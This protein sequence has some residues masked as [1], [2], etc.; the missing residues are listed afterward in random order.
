[1]YALYL[2][3]RTV[4]SWESRY[5]Y[6]ISKNLY[7]E[8]GFCLKI[9]LTT[10]GL[11]VFHAAFRIVP[12]NPMVVFPQV[13]IRFLVIWAIA[14]IFPSV[15]FFFQYFFLLIY[16]I[17]SEHRNVWFIHFESCLVNL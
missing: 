4:S 12:S 9:L 8:T 5:E 7:H 15:D 3:I 11:E 10:A 16:F 13:F 2:T 14:D 6:S 1:M 17:N